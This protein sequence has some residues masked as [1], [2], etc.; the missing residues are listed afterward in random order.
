M[1]ADVELITQQS[2]EALV[3]PA[4]AVI[5]ENET[6]YVYVA[7]GNEA[8]RKDIITGL[9]DGKITEVVSGLVSG[10]MVITKGKEFITEKN[11]EIKI[12]Q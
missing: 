4:E 1:I 3:V 12:T 7:Q 11:T 8:V 6:S 9:S 10:E 2:A 5:T